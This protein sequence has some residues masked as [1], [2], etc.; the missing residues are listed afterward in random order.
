[1]KRLLLAALAATILAAVLPASSSAYVYWA[2]FGGIGRAELD[3]AGS[4]RHFMDG[5]QGQVA[6]AVDSRHV[7]W[8]DNYDDTIAR[9][10]LDGTGIERSFI[11]GAAG[12]SGI[13][14]DAGRIY[15]TSFSTNSIG[16]ANLDGTGINR[17][18][19]TGA[20]SPQG[21]AVNGQNVFWG[22]GYTG[23]I[24][25]ATLSGGNVNQSFISG[26]TVP[27]AIAVDADHIYWNSW[28]WNDMANG[29]I[30]RANLNGT[31][32]NQSFITG[33]TASGLAADGSHVFWSDSLGQAIGR[34]NLDGSAV[35][36]SLVP[37]LYNPVGIAVDPGPVGPAKGHATPNPAALDLGSQAEYTIGPAKSA[38]IVNDGLG[39][40]HLGRLT[41]DGVDSD[42]F[43]VSHDECSGATL[44]PGQACAIRIRFAPGE[45]GDR[46]AAATVTTDDDA[47]STSIA[48][49]GTGA[50]QPQ[51]PTG[52]TG[53]TGPQ[54]PQGPAGPPGRD[55]QVTCKVKQRGKKAKVTCRVRYAT[56]KS[57]LPW[58]LTADR[59]VVRRGRTG[60]SG[61]VRIPAGL[62]PGR[63][64]LRVHGMR[65]VRIVVR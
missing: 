55:A 48:L 30:G 29:K 3:G 26:A 2:D 12:I 20:N 10:N 50:E 64:A 31:G 56:A 7:Y 57:R 45:T 16:R 25:R 49:A 34:A 38:E 11:T 58:R 42:D 8:A 22:N 27:S 52:P 13:A 28:N 54:G 44:T 53:P 9:A 62:E 51:G 39:D 37:R 60:P 6:V 18:F 19:I 61:R 23:T 59:E 1:M 4:V 32:V 65:P 47:G 17:S 5:P 46:T 21:I 15:W 35:N 36:E 24:G 43:L 63:Y 14:V 40:L 41:V 33:V